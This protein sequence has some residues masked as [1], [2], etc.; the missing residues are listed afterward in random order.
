MI[1]QNVFDNDIELQNLI[2]IGEEITRELDSISSILKENVDGIDLYLNNS[3][4]RGKTLD[5]RMF[6]YLLDKI[7]SSKEYINIFE[8][9]LELISN[10][11][12]ANNILDIENDFIMK[13]NMSSDINLFSRIRIEEYI[14]NVDSV[15]L[16]IEDITN[17]LNKQKSDYLLASR[18]I[19]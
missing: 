5:N 10:Y 15:R 11:D 1:N 18:F 19:M 16:I 14:K 4:Y 3:N 8:N 17:N 13:L 7:E 9:E 12:R 2:D 6:D